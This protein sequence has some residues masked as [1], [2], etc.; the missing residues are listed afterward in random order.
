[1]V[2]LA[3]ER[4]NARTHAEKHTQ[5][6]GTLMSLLVLGNAAASCDAITL[7]AVFFRIA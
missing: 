1:M 2:T 4:A 3:R 5:T 7:C 6:V